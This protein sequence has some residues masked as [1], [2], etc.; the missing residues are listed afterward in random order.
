MKMYEQFEK[1]ESSLW[2]E[3]PKSNIK[4]TFRKWASKQ[5]QSSSV[6]RTKIKIV[7]ILL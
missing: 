6:L 5:Q 3:D 7:K 1:S 4:S 2:D